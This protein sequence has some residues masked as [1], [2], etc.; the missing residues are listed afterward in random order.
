MEGQ[1]LGLVIESSPTPAIK[2]WDVK[3]ESCLHEGGQKGST[4]S[5]L[6]AKAVLADFRSYAT[7]LC[8]RNSFLELWDLRRLASPVAVSGRDVGGS[9]K[10]LRA[11]FAP[12][13]C[14]GLSGLSL[15][16]SPDGLLHLV[17]RTRRAQC[18]RLSIFHCIGSTKGWLSGVHLKV[19]LFRY[20]YH[21]CRFTPTENKQ[22]LDNGH[23]W[24]I[25]IGNMSVALPAV[26]LCEVL[27]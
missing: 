24:N 6:W 13:G 16:A 21:C 5:H 11:S 18:K 10:A 22:V 9:P 7:L 17:T 8:T 12:L 27:E 14:G 1:T 2:I 19:H 23:L 25:C 26:T 20:L 4:S 15:S 3:R